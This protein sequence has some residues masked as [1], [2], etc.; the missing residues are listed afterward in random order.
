MSRLTLIVSNKALPYLNKKIKEINK[1]T[2]LSK[3]YC[4]QTSRGIGLGKFATKAIK[5]ICLGCRKPFNSKRK[6]DLIYITDEGDK[7][8][9]CKKCSKQIIKKS[10]EQIEPIPIVIHW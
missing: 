5:K 3:L 10:A 1:M 7:T 6:R 9:C 2:N 8:A 4:E